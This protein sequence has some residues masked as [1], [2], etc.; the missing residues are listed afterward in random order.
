[1]L[2]PFRLLLP[3]L[4]PA[5]AHHVLHAEIKIGASVFVFCS[6]PFSK[7]VTELNAFENPLPSRPVITSINIMFGPL[8]TSSTPLTWEDRKRV[9]IFAKRHYFRHEWC[10]S[11]RMS[12]TSGRHWLKTFIIG[13]HFVYRGLGGRPDV[14]WPKSVFV[15]CINR[16]WLCICYIDSHPVAPNR[17]LRT[18]NLRGD[19]GVRYALDADESVSLLILHSCI[20]IR[21][22]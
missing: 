11:A 17:L 2:F 22:W 21:D 15:V 5:A 3:A 8:M 18:I 13:P 7:R 14:H 4:L 9:N 1:M 6:A 16:G 19:V 12:P 20:L 10:K